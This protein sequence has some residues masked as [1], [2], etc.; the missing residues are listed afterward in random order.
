MTIFSIGN[1]WYL[2]T[3]R[4]RICE[5]EFYWNYFSVKNLHIRHIFN[6]SMDQ[7]ILK[8]ERLNN[9]IISKLNSEMCEIFVLFKVSYIDSTIEYDTKIA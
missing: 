3:F 5:M 7:K 4:I 8:L 2:P 6:N 1:C 9:F